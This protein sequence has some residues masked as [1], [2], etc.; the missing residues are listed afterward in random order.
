M[1]INI[2]CLNKVVSREDIIIE[3]KT[4]E[5]LRYIAKMMVLK[6]PKVQKK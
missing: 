3:S 2:L 4:L 1:A 5:E 6:S